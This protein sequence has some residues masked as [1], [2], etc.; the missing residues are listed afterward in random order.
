M[1]P[2]IPVDRRPLGFT[3]MEL[4]TVI[5]IIAILSALSFVGIGRI[6]K[7]ADRNICAGNM[8]MI[9]QAVLLW[10]NDNRGRLPPLIDQKDGS[11]NYIAGTSWSNVVISYVDGKTSEAAK[12]ETTRR[13]MRCPEMRRVIVDGTGASDENQIT[14]VHQLRNFGFN[15]FLGPNTQNASNWRTL[16][17]IRNPSRTMMLSESGI[18]TNFN[19]VSQLDTGFIVQSTRGSDGVLRKGV[20]GDFNNIVWADGHVSA[21]E[22]ISRMVTA[23]YRPGSTDDLW[24][25]L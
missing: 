20:H 10:A 6:R 17:T 13:T 23:P 19:C 15:F 1:S 8:R 22:D 9:G 14:S 4:L 11:G 5:V 12:L 2:R 3:L 7:S 21:W 16:A 24:Q 25:G 18:Q